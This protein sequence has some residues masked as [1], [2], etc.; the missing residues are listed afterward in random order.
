[1]RR[2]V[3]RRP[4]LAGLLTGLLIFV[5]ALGVRLAYL[6][7]ASNGPTFHAPIVDAKNYDDLAREL[8][9]LIFA[10]GP[11]DEQLSITSRLN[12]FWQP[13]LYPYVLAAMYRIAEWRGADPL[14]F[15][16]LVQ[17]V[18][19]ALTCV[20]AYMLGRRIFDRWTGVIA[21]LA[22]ALC[23]PLIYYE[24][25][26]VAAGWAAFWSV[27]LVLLAV[28]AGRDGSILAAL[29]LGACGGL[30]VLMR[31]TFVP[32]LLALLVWLVVRCVRDKRGVVGSA[33]RIVPA[34]ALFGLVVY[35]VA[36]KAH[37][38][39]LIQKYTFLPVSGGINFYIGNNENVCE[40]LNT[41][42]GMTK[43][44]ELAEPSG[45][46][47]DTNTLERSQ[48]LGHKAW[49]FVSSHPL[50][51]L[52][53]LIQKGL[54]FASGRE[55][56]RNEDVYVFRRWSHVLSALLWKAGRFGFPWGVLFPLALVGLAWRWR[57][58]P[59]PVWLYVTLFP[60]AIILVFVSGRYRVATVP[61]FA[62]PAAACLMSII[63]A[64]RARKWLLVAGPL[65]YVAGLAV[66][67]SLPGQFCEER[68]NYEAEMYVWLG[69]DKRVQ[70]K[71]LLR[72]PYDASEDVIKAQRTEAQRLHDEARVL[73]E[74]AVALA[75]ESVVARVHLG[76]LLKSMRKYEDAISQ[77]DAALA[78]EPD[79]MA[80]YYRGDAYSRLRDQASALR[81]FTSCIE[82]EPRFKPALLARS[83]LYQMQGRVE[84]AKADCRRVLE[85]TAQV[86][87]YQDWKAQ[88]QQKI[89]ELRDPAKRENRNLSPPEEENLAKLEDALKTVNGMIDSHPDKD[90]ARQATARLRQLEQQP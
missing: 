17:V 1:V 84:E 73:Y 62:V 47:G 50:Q 39:G 24:A 23:G 38:F 56:P 40:T 16:K 10:S 60:L 70:A 53:G 78:Q 80:Y 7:E 76:Y 72:I 46:K 90:A 15:A 11:A 9:P 55:M 30:A 26:L 68:V 48:L 33:V 14:I 49:K 57:Q 5:L 85:L 83:A 52:G 41:R 3:I 66:V 31:P 43:W 6:Y 82:V 2:E 21:G 75:P 51:F 29:G 79:F 67:T 44:A 19:G 35:P 65:G 58:I 34:L 12:L 74:K 81:D 36:Q 4:E 64:A 13:F 27:T 8:S 77:F 18:L 25:D 37:N 63:R 28:K 45:A 54:R 20:L 86:K 59:A 61:V 88:L 89:Q 42:P 87:E 69:D 22:T 71:P 32:F